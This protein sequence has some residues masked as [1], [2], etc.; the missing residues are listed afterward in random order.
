MV[1]LVA[2]HYTAKAYFVSA[3]SIWGLGI[4]GYRVS[5]T[6]RLLRNENGHRFGRRMRRMASRY[7]NGSIDHQAVRASL[8]SWIGHESHGE[9]EGLRAALFSPVVFERNHK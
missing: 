9:T 1:C 7:K 6:R 5:R 2:N 4:L 3:F 8:Q